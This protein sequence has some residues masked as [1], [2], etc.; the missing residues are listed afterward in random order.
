EDVV[1]PSAAAEAYLEAATRREAGDQPDAQMEDLWRAFAVE[2][3]NPAVAA[4]LAGALAARGRAGAADEAWR[5]YARASL[6]AAL[7]AADAD[8]MH[9]RAEAWRAYE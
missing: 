3:A 7:N 2:P 5:A 9:A 1:P 6:G 4:A 8:A